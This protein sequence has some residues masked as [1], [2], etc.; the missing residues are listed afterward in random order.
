MFCP[1]PIHRSKGLAV[2]PAS[3][4]G[5]VAHGR[6]GTGAF[7]RCGGCLVAGGLMLYLWQRGEISDFGVT[8]RDISG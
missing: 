5:R 1:L 8:Y 2:T 3:D 7:T 4:H 6:A